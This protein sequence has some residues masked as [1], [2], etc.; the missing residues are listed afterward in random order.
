M[1]KDLGVLVNKKLVMSQQ[2]ALA[3]QRANCIQGYIK[4]GVASEEREGIVPL[5]LCKAPSGVLCPSLGPAV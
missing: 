3:A 2:R 4:R 5:C 1:R